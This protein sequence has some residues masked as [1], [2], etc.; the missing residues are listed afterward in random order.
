MRAENSFRDIFLLN[1][2]FLLR[3]IQFDKKQ[4]QANFYDIFFAKRKHK[5]NFFELFFFAKLKTL[6]STKIKA[7]ISRNI[8]FSVAAH[9]DTQTVQ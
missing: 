6:N 7:T 8:K 9:T 1:T 4:V 2:R 3:I 5:I